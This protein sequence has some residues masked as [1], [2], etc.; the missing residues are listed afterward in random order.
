MAAEYNGGG[1]G[2]MTMMMCFGHGGR[3]DPKSIRFY[4]SI[5]LYQEIRN[6]CSSAGRLHL[7]RRGYK[8]CLS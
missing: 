2:A 6:C 7:L 1:T 8:Y 3:V 4:K 5:R